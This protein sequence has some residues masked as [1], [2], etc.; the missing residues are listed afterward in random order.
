MAA[1]RLLSICILLVAAAGVVRAADISGIWSAKFT[2]QVGEQQY[3]YEFVVK[4][5]ALTGSIKSNLLGDSVIADG[6]VD[7][8]KVTFVENGKYMDMPIRIEYTG[9]IT[10]DNE[11]AFTRKVA[12]F[13][14]EDLV[15][16]RSK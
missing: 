14:S 12:D 2:T 1:R 13:G 3:T 8:N 10:N 6:K 15:A 7:G 16:R 11:I 5:T 4:G 9:T